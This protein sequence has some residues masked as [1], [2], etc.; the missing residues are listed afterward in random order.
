MAYDQLVSEGYIEAL[1]YRGYYVSKIDELVEVRHKTAGSFVLEKN[2][3]ALIWRVSPLI[4]G[5]S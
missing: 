3:G 4:H 5:A 2:Q 1:P